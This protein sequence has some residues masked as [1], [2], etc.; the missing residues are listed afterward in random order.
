MVTPRQAAKRKSPRR[1]NRESAASTRSEVK[2]IARRRGGLAGSSNINEI[3]KIL[4]TDI[5]KLSLHD[6]RHDLLFIYVCKY[7]CTI[8]ANMSL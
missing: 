4:A 1:E 6:S 3:D 5:S 7:V 2:L 8:D